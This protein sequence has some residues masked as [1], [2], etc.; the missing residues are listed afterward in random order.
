MILSENIQFNSENWLKIFN[1]RFNLNQLKEV[2]TSNE[3]DVNDVDEDDENA[4][5][6]FTQRKIGHPHF[7]NPKRY[8][9][10]EYEEILNYLV[11]ELKININH[12]NNNDETPIFNFITPT[13]GEQQSRE[14]ELYIKYG[15]DVNVKSF[16]ESVLRYA[17]YFY[18]DNGAGNEIFAEILIEHG[19]DFHSLC[20]FKN[21]K[22]YFNEWRYCYDILYKLI[23][24]KA[25]LSD[26]DFNKYDSLGETALTAF[27]KEVNKQSSYY[28]FD[29]DK[30][31]YLF[32]NGADF[33]K[34]NLK[35]ELP[36]ELVKYDYKS[37]LL[38]IFNLNNN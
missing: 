7:P 15:A 9:K 31:D 33:N 26:I 14:L 12:K 17:M 35:N 16:D 3:I 20:G 25:D 2:I 19:A 21:N 6:L 4:L 24:I 8:T 36:L 32:K 23:A 10:E 37:K 1:Y 30:F 13:L 18:D 38:K 29:D 34:K 5:H 28:L 11:N 22:Y 27:I